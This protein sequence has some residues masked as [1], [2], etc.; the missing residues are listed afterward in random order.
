MGQRYSSWQP[1]T[2]RPFTARPSDPFIL[3]EFFCSLF[4]SLR[5]FFPFCSAF[6][7]FLGS[8]VLCGSCSYRLPWSPCAKEEKEKT[9]IAYTYLDRRKYIGIDAKED[10]VLDIYIRLSCRGLEH[11]LRRAPNYSPFPP[12]FA[13]DPNVMSPRDQST[14]L[15]TRR[16]PSLSLR[17]RPRTAVLPLPVPK[18]CTFDQWREASL[19]EARLD[20][21]TLAV[22][23]MEPSS[24]AL[25]RRR[26]AKS[27]SNLRHPMDGLVALGRRLSV[28]IRSKSSKQSLCVPGDEEEDDCR[29]YQLSGH[30]HHRR[31]A[32]S[33]SWDSRLRPWT[34]G[35]S[36]NRRPSLNSVSALQGFY[37]PTASVPAPIPGHGMEPPILPNDKSAGAAAR[38]AAAAQNERMEMARLETARAER[39]KVPDVRLTQDSES[40]IGIDLRDRSDLSDS[41]LDF[42]R[43][44]KN[45]RSL[46]VNPQVLTEMQTPFLIYLP[47]SRPTF[48]LI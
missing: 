18:D 32:A 30:P 4:L 14:G 20:H 5:A 41:E 13:R 22:D 36:I 23:D 27:F 6:H 31:N 45:H 29:H 48:F 10:L 2:P 33:G 8:G 39:D 46:D 34:N 28:T 24:E 37:A 43:L 26:A 40:G 25:P 19:A 21:N 3:L 35:H 38:A 12:P 11:E 9:D 7:S 42:V 47:K 17:P 1:I 15:S 44:G 16:R